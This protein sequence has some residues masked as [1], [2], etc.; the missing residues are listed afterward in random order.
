LLRKKNPRWL[1]GWT[2]VQRRS[3]WGLSINLV[4]FT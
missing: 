1:T 3:R 2:R 4:L